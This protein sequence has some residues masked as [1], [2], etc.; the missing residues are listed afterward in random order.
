LQ[1][2]SIAANGKCVE[3]SK[4]WS[5]ELFLTVLRSGD[6]HPIM[7]HPTFVMNSRGILL[8]SVIKPHA[9]L[10]PPKNDLK[11]TCAFHCPVH[12]F[13]L[14]INIFDIGGKKTFWHFVSRLRWHMDDRP[15]RSFFGRK[16]HWIRFRDDEKSRFRTPGSYA[17]LSRQGNASSRWLSEEIGHLAILGKVFEKSRTITS[18]SPGLKAISFLQQENAH[19]LS[20]DSKYI[21]KHVKSSDKDSVACEKGFRSEMNQAKSHDARFQQV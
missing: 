18:I 10:L 4:Q 20:S 16:D 2:C 21:F 1:H 7:W 15:S 13:D 9:K 14:L 19:R 8:K 17:E 11:V 3:W 12:W 6:T 5:I